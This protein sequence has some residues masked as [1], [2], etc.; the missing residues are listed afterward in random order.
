MRRL[1]AAAL[2]AACAAAPAAGAQGAA[3]PATHPLAP[4]AVARAFFA[5]AAAA[6][7]R[8]AAGYV[9][10]ARFDAMR[11][12]RVEGAR[13]YSPLPVM[14]AA[15][16]RRHDPE[17]PQAVAEYTVRQMAEVRARSGDR[18][19][20]EYA[21]VPSADSLAR[22]P[23]I[24][25]AAR[26]LEAQDLRYQVRRALADERA[27]GC[28]AHPDMPGLP[29]ERP[30]AVLGAVVRDSAAYVLHEAAPEA[31]GAPEPTDAA[32]RRRRLRRAA[33]LEFPPA[34]LV[35]RPVGGAWRVVPSPGG[36]TGGLGS[37]GVSLDCTQQPPRGRPR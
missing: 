22:L 16:L 1:F 4:E 36:L 26:W 20:H 24:E 10:L 13:R 32:S 12:E 2:T 14:T 27:R 18:I 23:A 5:A 7:W 17:M 28:T 11:R 25:V 9:D 37:V 34:V 15:E 3:P 8:E 30:R 31:D 29:A 19:A 21:D 6:R 35:L 33:G